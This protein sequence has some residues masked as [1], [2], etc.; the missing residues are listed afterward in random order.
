MY[1]ALYRSYRPKL[2]DSIVGQDHITTTLQNA[3]DSG[4]VG[5]AYLFSGPRGTG[6]TSIAH[7]FSRMINVTAAGTEKDLSLDVIE[8]DA[9]SNNGVAEIRTLIDNAKYPPTNT[10]Y[11]VYI[12]D[13]V[14][15]LSKSA[16]NALLKILE[17]PPTYVV[18]I[19]ATTEVHKIP[20]TILSRTQRFNFRRIDNQLIIKNLEWIL[21]KENIRYD[22][23][24]L[25][26]IAKLANGGMRDALSIADQVG[27]F[28]N[29]EIS[30]QNIAH[31]FGIVSIS[32]QIKLI[33]NIY[34]SNIKE[35]IEDIN[36]MFDNGIDIERLITS[37][38]GIFKDYIIYHKTKSKDLLHEISEDLIQELL[39]SLDFAY[40]FSAELIDL[41]TKIK[42]AEM[43]KTLFELSFLKFMGEDKKNVTVDVKPIVTKNTDPVQLETN[44]NKIVE[45]LQEKTQAIEI[46]EVQQKTDTNELNNDVNTQ[47]IKSIFGLE[48][49]KTIERIIPKD[50]SIDELTQVISGSDLKKINEKHVKD[51]IPFNVT[52]EQLLHCLIA[53]KKEIVDSIMSSWDLFNSVYRYDSSFSE[54]ASY[55]SRQKIITA[56]PNYIL[57]SSQDDE[58]VDW[59]QK[60]WQSETMYSLMKKMFAQVFDSVPLIIPIGVETFKKIK[61]EYRQLKMSNSLPNLSF[62]LLPSYNVNYDEQSDTAEVTINLVKLSEADNED[63]EYDEEDE[64]NNIFGDKFIKSN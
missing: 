6:K 33:N 15:M 10:K 54:Y 50:L 43:P 59:I 37:L 41:L 17:E 29:G 32:R 21:N 30:L 18:F 31:I 3:I 20:I 55:L 60:N 38:V 14:H 49:T 48:K 57:V 39:I 46:E 19:L 2:F 27:A 42:N 35:V 7:I 36:N 44:L 23:E 16:W 61:E 9:A 40:G 64:L 25:S 24:S 8:I 52:D 28:G 22:D 5:H 11:K 53:A 62:E 26:L 63:D 51:N 58:S 13:E 34:A 12:V 47:N 56:G 1:K 45:E 4:K